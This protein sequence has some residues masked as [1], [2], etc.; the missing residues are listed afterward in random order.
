MSRDTPDHVG[1]QL[2]LGVTYEELSDFDNAINFYK[3][4]IESYPDYVEPHI[5][6]GMCYLLNGN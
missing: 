2:I 1:C 3:S 6:L 4:C 5:N